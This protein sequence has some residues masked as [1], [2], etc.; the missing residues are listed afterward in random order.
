M[1][2]LPDLG[3]LVVA[4]LGK[5]EDLLAPFDNNLEQWLSY[6]SSDQP[7][8]SDSDNMRNRAMFYDASLAVQTCIAAC[9]KAA[10]SK[11]P[12]TWALRLIWRWCLQ[13]ADVATLNYDVLIERLATHLRFVRS[14]ADLYAMSV[15]ERHPPGTGMFLG[16]SDPTD[17]VYTLYKL[18]GSTNWMYGGP[19]APVTEQAV[20]TDLGSGWQAAVED[21]PERTTRYSS[22][23]D[24][25]A[26]LIVPPTGTK[27]PYYGNRSLRA[28][29]HKAFKQLKRAETVT[30]IGYSFP[31]SDLVTRHFCAS[32]GLRCPV[33]VV[34][35]RRE[36]A[37][38]IQQLAP[39]AQVS[40]VAG[41]DALSSYVDSAC[42]DLVHWAAVRTDEGYISRLFVNGHDLLPGQSPDPDQVTA[43]LRAERWIDER[44]PGVR[45]DPPRSMMDIN[46]NV[47]YWA[48]KSKN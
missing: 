19:D 15:T 40:V 46:D 10:L 4:E 6:L 35:Y 12:P 42:G 39:A 14:W 25:L 29:W 1:P 23:Y 41:E 21:S 7:W 2:L 3:R 33:T 31:A 37:E 16:Y 48:V 47:W 45:P 13:R 22:L 5:S 17:P 8:L 30:V 28:Q 24:D 11:P 9:E 20:V 32:A 18:H 36:A 44:W 26:P 38:P 27:A 34:D 43:R